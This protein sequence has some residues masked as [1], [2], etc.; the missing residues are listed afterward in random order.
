MTPKLRLVQLM[1][2]YSD[3]VRIYKASC[4]SHPADFFA[5]VFGRQLMMNIISA[6]ININRIVVLYVFVH[7]VNIKLIDMHFSLFY[8]FIP[9]SFTLFRLTTKMIFRY[10]SDFT[11][12]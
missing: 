3:K 7:F 1:A 2:I 6:H 11:S 10:M 5:L 9:E 12:I 4:S 8:L